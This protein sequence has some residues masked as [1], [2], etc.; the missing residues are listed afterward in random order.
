MREYYPLLIVGAALG[1]LSIVFIVAYATM[2]NKKEAIGFDRNMK[3]GEIVR[4]LLAYAKPHWRSFV[5]VGVVMLTS[6]AYDIIAPLITGEIVRMVK[7][8]FELNRLFVLIAIYASILI[9]SMLSSY[10][11]AMILQ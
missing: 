4:R 1:I 6:I 3:D 2:K 7:A 11:Q 10:A 8:D 5:L 9:V